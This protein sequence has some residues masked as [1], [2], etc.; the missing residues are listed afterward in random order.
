MKTYTTLYVLFDDEIVGFMFE[1][2]RIFNDWF[3]SILKLLDDNEWKIGNVYIKNSV[4][5]IDRVFE[6]VDKPYKLYKISKTNLF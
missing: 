5:I 4:T 3:K 6:N 2:T 1:S